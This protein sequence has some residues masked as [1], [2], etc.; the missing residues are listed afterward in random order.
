MPSIDE[1]LQD[2]LTP[3]QCAAA[4]DPA[5]EVLCLACAGS[6]KSRTLAFRIARLVAQGEDPAG[7]VAFTFTVKAAE[8]IKRQV[9]KA[10]QAAGLEPTILGAMYVGTIHSYC[11][12]ILGEIN[13]RYR[14]F[15]VLDENRLKLYLISRYPQLG[16][17][18]IRSARQA[19]YF[20]TILEVSNAWKTMNDE[21]VQAAA[22]T[23]EDPD[24]GRT[25]D[26]LR[27][28][29]DADNFIDFS[30][31]VRNVVDAL[32]NRDPNALRA[33]ERLQHLMVDEYQD[34]NPVQERLISELHRRSATLFVVG[35]D[36]QAIYAWRGADVNNILTFQRRSSKCSSHTL[37]HNFRSTPAIV[38][39]ADGFAAAELGATRI[40]KNPSA[41]QPTGPRD[42]RVVWFNRRDEEGEWVASRIQALLGTAYK[43]RDGTTRGLTPADFAILMRSTRSEEEDGSP[44]HGAFTRALS[45]LNIPFTLKAGGTVFDRPQVSVLR[46]TFNLLRDGSP[47]RQIAQDHFS[48]LVRPSFP[49]ADFTLFAKVLADWGRRIH[50]PPGG[51][52]RRVYPQE[53]VHDLLNAFGLQQSQFDAGVLGDLGIFSRI[54]QDVEAV[55]LSIDTAERFQDILNFLYNVADIG[56]DTGTDDVLTAPDAVTVSTVHQVK[57]LEFPVVFV[58]DVEANRF[59]GSRGQYRGWLPAAVIQGAIQR[60]AY[61]KTREEEA[62]LFYTAITRAERYLHVSGSASLPGGKKTWKQSPFT[63]RLVH[64]EINDDPAALPAKLKR[65]PP[66][67]RI[68]E[69]VVPTSYSDIRYY[70]RCPRDYQFRKSFGFSPSIPEM[71]GFG[72]TVHAAVCKLHELY[73]SKA[74]KGDQ[75][76]KAAREIF[77]LK[78]VAPSRD[79]VNRPGGYER[80]KER[81][82]QIAKTYAQDYQADFTRSRQVEARFEIPVDQAVISGSIDLLLKVDERQKIVDATVID[83]KAMEGGEEPEEREELHWTELALQVQL[84][85][86]AARE[87][88]GENARTGSV[89]MLKDNQRVQVPVTDESIEAAVENV[90]WAVARILAGDFPMRPHPK[91][92]EGCDFAKLCPKRTEAF[93]TDVVPPPLHV[94]GGAQTQQVRAFSELEDN[95]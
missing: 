4:R 50:A 30:L 84:Y 87:V 90:E 60:G 9:A 5:A 78:H 38:T 24:L 76:E 80:A 27:T 62:R 68:D 95:S 11:Q 89:H 45:R 74:P 32:A 72:Q 33:T 63:L 36:D 18:R 48:N 21:M 94:P 29:M 23:A 65:H 81:A 6:G 71:F 53:L 51:P 15:D 73:T 13:A 91:K 40:A 39:A 12:Y 75:A 49:Q 17:N 34:V 44:R 83:F 77:H 82:G 41:D 64:P 85:A 31:M 2:N 54:I 88:L 8:S 7:I 3:S 42:F 70:L 69:K 16:L 19:A 86:K 93:Q 52:R 47:T 25:L 22:V 66:A 46:E 10:L 58:S 56:Y 55:Y 1:I 59:P 14:Q 67:R 57:G 35:D 37:S 28:R 26:E 79:P 92:C 61:Q 20:D 43:E